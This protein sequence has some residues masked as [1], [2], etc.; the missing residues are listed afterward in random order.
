MKKKLDVEKTQ[1][2]EREV[3]GGGQGGFNT[4][5]A[6]SVPAIDNDEARKAKKRYRDVNKKNSK[7]AEIENEIK[8]GKRPRMKNACTHLYKGISPLRAF[9]FSLLSILSGRRK[10][11]APLLPVGI[12]RCSSTDKADAIFSSFTKYRDSL[13]LFICIFFPPTPSNF[14]QSTYFLL[15]YR[16]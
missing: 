15:F 3:D 2:L 11:Y 12:C 4:N 10:R 1:N 14:L 7:P 13:F 9:I 6:N 8:K 16:Y 5:L